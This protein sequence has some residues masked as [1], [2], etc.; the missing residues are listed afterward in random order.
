MATAT[1]TKWGNSQGI[2]IPKALCDQM[3]LAIGDKLDITSHDGVLEIKPARQAYQRTRKTSIDE[4]FKGWNG[5][6]EPPP[7]LT[8]FGA[9]VDW[10]EPAGNEVW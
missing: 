5:S 2:L 1:L 8:A 10:G 6:Y 4:V 9:E 7:D 3:E